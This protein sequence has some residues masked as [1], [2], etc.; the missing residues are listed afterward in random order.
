MYHT[1]TLSVVFFLRML[2]IYC[3]PRPSSIHDPVDRQSS[4][5]KTFFSNSA[6]FPSSQFLLLLV[7]VPFISHAQA[8]PVH[9]TKA[10]PKRFDSIHQPERREAAA[11]SKAVWFVLAGDSTTA[12][13]PADKGGG[14]WGR[15]FLRTLQSPAGGVNYAQNGA[16]TVSFRQDK[17]WEKVIAETKR[18]SGSKPVYVTIQVDPSRCIYQCM[19]ADFATVRA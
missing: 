6:M 15:G 13:P 3:H 19:K 17:H 9:F 8:L 11:D 12:N 2:R 5:L 14:G 4:V 10:L 18:Q 7:V 16:T 1:P